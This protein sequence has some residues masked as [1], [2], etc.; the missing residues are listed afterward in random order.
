MLGQDGQAPS[1]LNS[2]KEISMLN[3]AVIFLVIAVVA[4]IFGFSGVAGAAANIAWILAVIGIVL[5]VAFFVM[6]RR[7]PLP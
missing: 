6:G 7:P 2:D 5:A 4:A 3:W 1:R